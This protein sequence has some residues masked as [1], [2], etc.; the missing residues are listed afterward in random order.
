MSAP[1]IDSRPH[2]IIVDMDG[3]LADCSHRVHW[4]AE[5]P[6]N[7]D[8]FHHECDKDPVHK[9]IGVLVNCLSDQDFKIVV[10]SGRVEATRAKTEAWL[11]KNFIDFHALFMRP[12][13]DYRADDVLKEEI[14][15]RDILPVWNPMMAL[16]D[17]DRVVAMWRRRGV[18]CLQV[19]AG[20]F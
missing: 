13:G 12:D 11:R 17:R 15:D 8:M 9:H 20:D 7:W 1:Q 4:I 3:T 5:K 10:V 6:K 19:A 2:C 18:P 16:D 14:L